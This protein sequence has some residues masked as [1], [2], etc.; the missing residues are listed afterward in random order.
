MLKK[1]GVNNPTN[2]QPGILCHNIQIAIMLRPDFISVKGKDKLGC[3][4]IVGFKPLS[5]RGLFRTA[6]LALIVVLDEWM[7]GGMRVDG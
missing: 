1:F 6:N 2:N 3:H 7:D 5:T 4:S